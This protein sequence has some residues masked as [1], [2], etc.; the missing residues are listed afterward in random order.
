V[1][2]HDAV[3]PLVR[4]ELIE[5][6]LRQGRMGMT[7]GV[8]VVDALM[9]CKDGALAREIPRDQIVRIQTPQ[10][11]LFDIL[12]DAHLKA[13]ETGITDATDDAGL[14][15]RTGRRVT[16][17]EGDPRNIKITTPADIEFAG[18]LLEQE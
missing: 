4:T 7:F 15:L 2:I 5:T 10:A 16:V 3:R 12:K 11:F 9:E 8:P 18:Y 1:V 6:A 17:M 14:V 13:R